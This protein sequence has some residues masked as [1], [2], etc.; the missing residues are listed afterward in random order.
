MYKKR[1]Q[2]K[3]LK[4]NNPFA[5]ILRSPLFK[6]KIKKSNKIYNRKKNKNLFE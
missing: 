2:K 6:S 1:I 4:K 5:K 3:L